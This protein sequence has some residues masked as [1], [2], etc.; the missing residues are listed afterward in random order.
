MRL[1]IF[2]LTSFIFFVISL[3]FFSKE[4]FPNLTKQSISFPYLSEKPL[5]EDGY[6]ALTVAWNIG[7]GKGISYN[8][9][10]PTT[11]F[12]P[13]YVFILAVIAS[14]TKQLSMGKVE[15]ARMV[16]LFSGIQLIFFIKII[17]ALSFS[18]S[19]ER[20]GKYFETILFLLVLFNYKIFLNFFNGLETG[21]YITLIG[22]SVLFS[23]NLIKWSYQPLKFILFGFILGLTSLARVDFILPVIIFLSIFTWMYKIPPR[24]IA[25]SAIFFV[26]TILPWFMY[27]F[28]ITGSFYP[29]SVSVQANATIFSDFGYRIDQ[30]FVSLINPFVPFYF[31]GIK[32]TALFYIPALVIILFIYRV[33]LTSKPVFRY[34]EI[35]LFMLWAITL[36]PLILSYLLFAAV[37][38]FYFRYMSILLIFTLPLLHLILSKYLSSKEPRYFKYF[39]FVVLIFFSI[40]I[41]YGQF[42]GREGTSLAVRAK[43]IQENFSKE[44]KIGIFQSGIAGYFF[45]NVVNLDGKM[46]YKALTYSKDGLLHHYLDKECINI[47]LEWKEQFSILDSN[48]FNRNWKEFEKEVPD[49]KSIAYIRKNY[50]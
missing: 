1:R 3:S 50:Y 13:L 47:L 35:M 12:Q 49:G 15:F 30:F 2:L 11:G 40:N 39:V 20:P 10:E 44:Q 5:I 41:F 34:K 25:L 43:F 38:Y 36:L 48:Y 33:Y 45:E 27:V 23:I 22:I 6:Y 16:I 18:L 17:K 31:S 24:A 8:Y 37:P 46:N 29:S 9:S 19:E 42:W 7:T 21:L 28:S 14:L 4:G 32:N 26:L